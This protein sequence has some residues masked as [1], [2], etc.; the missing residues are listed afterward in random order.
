MKNGDWRL[1]VKYLEKAVK[2]NPRD[3]DAYNLLA[4]SYRRMGKL[5]PAFEYYAKA[6]DID[7]RHRGAHEYVGEAYL[8]VGDLA[9]A[10]RHLSQ[11]K[12]ICSGGCNEAMKL[13]KSIAR[14]KDGNDKQAMLD[15]I[16]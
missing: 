4:Y 16:W 14:Y 11:L 13:R 8:M 15:D 10:Q 1:A 6:L 3:A 5:D 2:L 12:E 7:P 9:A